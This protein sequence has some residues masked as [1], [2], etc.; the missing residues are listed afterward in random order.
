MCLPALARGR[1]VTRA[2]TTGVLHYLG[3]AVLTRA[4]T[5]VTR[6]ARGERGRHRRLRARTHRREGAAVGDTS[7][8]V[9]ELALQVS[10]QPAAVLALERTQVVDP[11]LE[12]LAVWTSE[13][14]A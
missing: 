4:L 6:A 14:M 3:D 9:A 12:F 11:A 7:L 8:Q 1:S 5:A 10:L 2:E 13:P